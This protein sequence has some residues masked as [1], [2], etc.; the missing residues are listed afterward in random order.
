M[1]RNRGSEIGDDHEYVLPY[2]ELEGSSPLTS[3]SEEWPDND[4]DAENTKKGRWAAWKSQVAMAKSMSRRFPNAE[5]REPAATLPESLYDKAERHNGDLTDEE[6]ALLRSQHHTVAWALA[7]PAS[8]A[9]H[10]RYSVMQWSEPS[11]LHPAIREATAGAAST[12]EE[13]YALARQDGGLARLRPL[14]K[15][16]LARNFWL[17]DGS[18]RTEWHMKFPFLP[19][20]RQAMNLLLSRAGVDMAFLDTVVPWVLSTPR[21]KATP[22]SVARHVL[23]VRDDRQRKVNRT[24]RD[25]FGDLQWPGGLPVFLTTP[26]SL[27]F[28]DKMKDEFPGKLYEAVQAQAVQRWWTLTDAEQEPYK[29]QWDRLRSDAWDLRSPQ[30]GQPSTADLQ[31]AIALPGYAEFMAHW[32]HRYDIP[33]EKK[34]PKPS[35]DSRDYQGLPKFPC[36]VNVGRFRPRGLFWEDLRAQHPGQS[37]KELWKVDEE[38]LEV[39]RRFDALSDEERAPYEARSEKLRQDLWD[40]WEAYERRELMPLPHRPDIHALPLLKSLQKPE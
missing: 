34:R 37:L 31:Q 23:T 27:Y 14:A 10:H 32:E 29:Q 11:K 18:Y 35:R 2:D 39:W 7:D 40:E 4:V 24:T 1:K 15:R 16:I 36:H 28:H 25:K 9:E 5:R 19:G 30:G 3:E 22:F 33:E 20:S 12:P 6:R 26:A 13:L 8:L 38:I 17:D 21:S